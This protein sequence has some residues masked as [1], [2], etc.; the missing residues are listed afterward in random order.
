MSPDSLHENK[1]YIN[2]AKSRPKCCH[3][4]GSENMIQIRSKN[5]HP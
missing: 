4:K 2:N 5:K 3:F 1:Y